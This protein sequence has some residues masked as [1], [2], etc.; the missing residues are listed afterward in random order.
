MSGRE[1][2]HNVHDL[3]DLP[4]TPFLSAIQQ[5]SLH[6]LDVANMAYTNWSAGRGT[7]DAQIAAR[8]WHAIQVA[9]TRKLYAI[10]GHLGLSDR[11]VRAA[12]K[13]ETGLTPAQWRKLIRLEKSSHAITTSTEPM[14][15]VALNA[16]YAD[17]S[18]MNRD[19]IEL[20]G[21]SPAMLRRSVLNG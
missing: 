19:F 2:S 7:A 18:H 11:R 4:A 16:G 3:S 21:T 8:V 17:Q 6:A 1:L 5:G 15:A 14:S 10:A 20:A 9:P 12:V 13:E